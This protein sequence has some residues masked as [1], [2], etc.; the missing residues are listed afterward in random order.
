[1]YQKLRRIGVVRGLI[2][3]LFFS[4]TTPV[5]A[6]H[7]PVKVVATLN[8]IDELLSTKFTPENRDDSLLEHILESSEGKGYFRSR[9]YEKDVTQVECLAFAL[10]G[11]A[12]GEDYIGVIS[13]AFVIHNR[14]N[15]RNLNYCEVIKEPY[16]FAFRPSRPKNDMDKEAWEKLVTLAYYLIII[17]GFSTMESPVGDAMYFNAVYAPPFKRKVVRTLGNHRFYK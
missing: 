10:Y 9:L 2:F 3:L 7:N 5:L 6:T 1:M 12:R 8:K 16:Q 17:D 11:E 4:L 13:V 15:A 14:V